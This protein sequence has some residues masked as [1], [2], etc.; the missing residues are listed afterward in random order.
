MAR[1]IWSGAI[2]FGLVNVPVKLYPAVRSNTLRF[3]QLT[4]EGQRVRQKRVAGPS[5]EEVAWEDIVKGYELAPGQYVLVDPEELDALDPEASRTIDI[6]DFV[7]LADIDPIYYDR[8]YFL[9]PADAAAARPYRL[10]VEAMQGTS[11]VAIARFVMRTKQYLAALRARDDVL[12]LSTMNYADEIVP[13]SEVDGLAAADQVEIR[14][15]E[16]Q[17]ARQLIE[18]L[19]TPFEPGRYEDEYRLRVLELI[20][21]RA[22]GEVLVSE[23]TVEQAPRVV[24]LMSALEESLEAAKERKDHQKAG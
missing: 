16:L 7:E 8:P 15:R 24:D 3:H 17:M 18:S 21:R 10:L 5:S 2:S 14:D 19:T 9:A 20:E 1:A 4:R 22:A 6:E 23:P 13:L 12:V 11:K